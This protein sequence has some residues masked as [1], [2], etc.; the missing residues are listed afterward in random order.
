M[1]FR[2]DETGFC[3]DDYIPPKVVVD[4][5]RYAPEAT[6]YADTYLP[7]FDEASAHQFNLMPQDELLHDHALLVW[8]I[9][10]YP[11]YVLCGFRSVETGNTLLFEMRRDELVGIDLELLRW[12]IFNRTLVG[13]NDTRFDLLI[14][15]GILAGWTTD[16]C[17]EGTTEIIN[18]LSPYNFHLTFNLD[19][20]HNNHIDL[21][22]LTPLGPSLK[23]CAGRLHA[24]LM[25]DLPFEPGKE[26]TEDQI[27]ILKWY[28]SNDLDNTALL[29]DAHRP[30]IRL[31]EMM[32]NQYRTDVRSKS[33]PQIAEAVIRSELKRAGHWQLKPAAIRYGHKFKYTPPGYVQFHTQ[34]MQGVLNHIRQCE[35]LIDDSGSPTMPKALEKLDVNIGSATYRM[36]IGGLHSQEK[37]SVH[38][39][40][41]DH[42]LMDFD[43]TS[44]YPALILQLGMYP[45]TVGESFLNVYR[46]LFQRRLAAKKSGNKHDAETLKIVLNG[47]F[48]KTGE[49]GGRSIM[50]HPEMMIAVTVT[51]QLSLLMLIEALELCNIQVVSANTDGVM[52]K[53][54]THLKGL[55]DHIVGRWE[56]HTGLSMEA[57][58]CQAIF[59]KDVNNY[60]SLYADGNIKSKGA[61]AHHTLK[62]NPTAEI[63]VSA[64]ERYLK[65]AIPLAQTINEC[66]DVRQFVKMRQVRG[67]ACKDG[68]YLGKAIRWYYATGEQGPILN[69]K[70]GHHVPRSEGAKPIMRLP[71]VLPDD[72][73]LAFYLRRAEGMLLDLLPPLHGL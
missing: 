59:S 13:F 53:C 42:E 12:V 46:S 40:D 7:H 70:N 8:D 68:H 25:Q 65:S 64:I 54:A 28:W 43:V 73:D 16:Q 39:S 18:G 62:K 30:Q 47:T 22:E 41:A 26:L 23:V 36:G 66:Q 58:R 71:T 55:R 19:P 61:Y 48:G 3:W 72:I 5:K 34:Y 67:G 60:L 35:F 6:W 44:Y 31:R 69:A 29:Y 10:I 9:E 52:V 37:R 49:R 63:C 56:Q 45:P 1:G 17:W 21:I 15:A 38:Y 14:A 33:D 50:Y 57:T 4:K 2:F 11:N 51:G 24:P 27:T 32:T 20:I